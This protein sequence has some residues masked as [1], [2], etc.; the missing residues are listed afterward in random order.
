MTQVLLQRGEEE[1]P[2]WSMARVVFTTK[3]NGPAK[4]LHQSRLLTLQAPVAI[5]SPSLGEEEPMK[6]F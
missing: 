1:E 6:H 4:S 5:L 3:A 2:L